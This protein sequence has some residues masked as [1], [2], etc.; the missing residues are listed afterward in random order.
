MQSE[1]GEVRTV[2]NLFNGLIKLFLDKLASVLFL[3]RASIEKNVRAFQQLSCAHSAE[4][5]IETDLTFPVCGLHSP[6]LAQPCILLQT[7]ELPLQLVETIMSTSP[8]ENKP[9]ICKLA[10]SSRSSLSSREKIT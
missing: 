5:G 9:F 8:R 7:T 6:A 1:Q 3:C 10:N 2:F 4:G